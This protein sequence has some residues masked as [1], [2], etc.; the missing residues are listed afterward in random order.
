MANVK[1]VDIRGVLPFDCGDRNPEMMTILGILN[2]PMEGLRITY[3][4]YAD[5]VP[6]EHGGKTAMV[7]FI[8]CGQ[9]ATSDLFLVR[10]V[11]AVQGCG[12][13]VS[14]ATALDMEGGKKPYNLLKMVK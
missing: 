12:G 1:D 13:S 4:G 5:S 3:T 10:M 8:I 2:M 9:G 6:N 14:K 11:K 7:Y